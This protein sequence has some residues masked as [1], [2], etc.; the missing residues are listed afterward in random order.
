MVHKKVRFHNDDIARLRAIRQEYVKMFGRPRPI[1][2]L[3]EACLR[4]TRGVCCE[5]SPKAPRA[6]S[7]KLDLWLE[8][9]FAGLDPSEVRD[10]VHHA[11]NEVRPC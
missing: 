3:V 4:R 10:R 1:P 2:K 7:E 5:K 11:L 9:E 6:E 8:E